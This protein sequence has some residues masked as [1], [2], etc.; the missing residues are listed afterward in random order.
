MQ[1]QKTSRQKGDIFLVGTQRRQLDSHYSEP[2][3]QIFAKFPRAN[4]RLQ[5]AVR[6]ADHPNVHGDR[7]RPAKPLNG[8]IFQYPQDFRLGHWIHV[9]N[10]VQEN[11]AA[12]SQLEFP[13][14]LLRRA[15]KRSPLVTKQFRFDECL[16]QCR[17]IHRHIRFAAP[18]RT[19][20]NLLRQQILS[21]PALA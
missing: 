8:A 3:E 15:R 19:R 12:R 1:L 2:V 18:W 6:R 11:R 14:F 10:F 7:L 9:P 17:A 21:R 16:R 13:F 5:I 20:M 4:F